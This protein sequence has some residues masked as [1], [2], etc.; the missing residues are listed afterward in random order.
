MDNTLF[1]F[2]TY[3]FFFEFVVIYT[4]FTLSCDL[5]TSS[6]LEKSRLCKSFN[7]LLYNSLS[8]VISFAMVNFLFHAFSLYCDLLVKVDKYHKCQ[9]NND[10][11]RHKLYS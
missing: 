11:A 8:L 6:N 5:I 2:E 10:I 9:S 3:V 7:D 1:L 4:S